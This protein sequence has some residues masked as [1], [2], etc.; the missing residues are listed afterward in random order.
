MQRNLGLDI[1][2]SIAIILVMVAHLSPFFTQN[3]IIFNL[4]YHSG[5]Y[6]VELFFILSGF[7]IGQIAI[8]KFTP[9]FSFKRLKTFYF[10]RLLRILPLYYSILILFLLISYFAFKLKS[11]HLLHFIFLQNLIESEVSFF[12]VSWTLSIQFWFYI[13]IPIL[14]LFFVRKKYSLGKLLRSLLISIFIIIFLRAL[15]ILLYNPTF[16]FGV[17]KNIFFRFDSLLIGVLFG[18]FK[19][20]LPSLYKKL[21]NSYFFLFSLIFLFVFYWFYVVVM[22]NQGIQYFDGSFLFRAFSWPF[23]S[24]MF[25]LFTIY[26]ENS[27]FI[28]KILSGKKVVLSFFTRLSRYSFSLFLIHYEIYTYFETYLDKINVAITIITATFIICVLSYFLYNFIEKP[29]LSKRVKFT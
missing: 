4:L 21:A 5:L 12:A 17:R 22:I 28:N 7:L 26:F 16:D 15:Y 23:M 13:F 9:N 14:L 19:L 8:S 20:K 10:R 6:G 3:P 18:L 29:F 27:N 2:R 25:I 24:L 11:I 1:V